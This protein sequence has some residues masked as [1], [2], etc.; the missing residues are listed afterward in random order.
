MANWCDNWLSIE[1]SEAGTK[2]FEAFIKMQEQE[3]IT[4]LGQQIPD[5][6]MEYFIFEI[7]CNPLGIRFETKWGTSAEDFKKIADFFGA[8]FELDYSE[9]GCK[10]F[11]RMVFKDGIFN[12]FHL[13]YEEIDSY[14]FDSDKDRYIFR[15]EEYEVEEEILETLLE[16]KINN[17][18]VN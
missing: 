16:E 8:N 2:L 10:V 9:L 12:D 6:G 11:G 4:G 1:E 17:L 3:K 18:L 5:L 13:D 7:D 14:S 15:G